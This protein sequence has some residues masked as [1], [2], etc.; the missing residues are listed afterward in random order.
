[1]I[2]RYKSQAARIEKLQQLTVELK[3]KATAE[4]TK[5]HQLT[6]HLE[7]TKQKIQ[8]LASSRQIYQEVD[9]KDS[10]LAATSKQC[11]DCKDRDF[12]LRL[13]IQ[14]L[15]QSIP[16]FLTKVTKVQHPKQVPETELGDAVSKLEDETT[17]LIKMISSALLK[18]ATPDDLALMSQQ[19]SSVNADNTSEFARLRRLPGYSRLQRQLYFNLMTARP[20]MTDLNLRV[21]H[22]GKDKFPKTTGG[23][24]ADIPMPVL[25]TNQQLLVSPRLRRLQM[26]SNNGA[27]SVNS[28]LLGGMVAQFG[29]FVSAGDVE[30]E[31]AAENTDAVQNFD[32]DAALDRPTIK[33][34]S[35]LISERDNPKTASADRKKRKK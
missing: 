15:R 33:S 16:R 13:N 19:Q 8:Q 4:E 34:I 24:N 18:D 17:K 27:G 30:A 2:E 11:D 12:K 9:V 23:E 28:R 29:D 22:V 25:S 6:E 35:K 5:K 21:E 32:F 7:L 26:A 20:D 14:S 1:M 31:I 3:L 10:A